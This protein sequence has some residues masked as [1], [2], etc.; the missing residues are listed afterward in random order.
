MISTKEQMISTPHFPLLGWDP[1]SDRPVHV[2]TWRWWSCYWKSIGRK[3]PLELRTRVFFQISNVL[4]F[5]LWKI[6]HKHA[7][8]VFVNETPLELTFVFGSSF[9]KCSKKH[10]SS[11]LDNQAPDTRTHTH[12]FW[13]M[14]VW[15]LFCRVALVHI[16]RT[17]LNCC[18]TG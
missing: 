17:H 14:F 2:V 9:S 3:L 12:T 15:C 11:L 1:V 13:Y 6:H 18:F 8:D 5:H 10:H 4:V 7:T 16:R